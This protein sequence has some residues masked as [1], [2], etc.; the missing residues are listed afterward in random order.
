[1]STAGPYIAK[2]LGIEW[3]HHDVVNQEVIKLWLLL[4]K[5]VRLRKIEEEI[6]EHVHG[7]LDVDR[8]SPD[9][10]DRP[11]GFRR[12]ILRSA[13]NAEVSCSPEIAV[14]CSRNQIGLN[15]TGTG[16]LG[17]KAFEFPVEDLNIS[18]TGSRAKQ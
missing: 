14:V 4:A 12:H 11:A 7:F 2:A 8:C 6:L 3:L 18:T 1:M 16:G 13:F 5:L 10:F 17:Q 9:G 15:A